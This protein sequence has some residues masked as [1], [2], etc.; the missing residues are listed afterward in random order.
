MGKKSSPCFMQKN[1]AESSKCVLTV[2]HTFNK[3]AFVAC[4]LWMQ[5]KIENTG[6]RDM[7]KKS[8]ALMEKVI[9]L[10]NNGVSKKSVHSLSESSESRLGATCYLQNLGATC[11]VNNIDFLSRA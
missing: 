1:K 8:N 5:Q 11:Y 3:N 10:V 9:N 7:T 6:D 4:I 2:K